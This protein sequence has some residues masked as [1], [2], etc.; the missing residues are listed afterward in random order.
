MTLE[1]RAELEFP[2]PEDVGLKYREYN[3][4]SANGLEK[5]VGIIG[6]IHLYNET[7]KK[8]VDQVML[9]YDAIAREGIQTTSLLSTMV[10][11]STKPILWIIKKAIPERKYL[12]S[13][14]NIPIEKQ[15][16]FYDLEPEET[17]TLGE[18]I[19]LLCGFLVTIAFLPLVYF[20]IKSNPHFRDPK[21][22]DNSYYSLV[23]RRDKTMAKRA[24]EII[25]QEDSGNVLL[26][27]GGAHLEGVVQHLHQYLIMEETK[28][29]PETG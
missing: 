5:K 25:Q 26:V 24:A 11:H 19:K 23:H 16:H 1:A 10:Y 4:S 8:F 13:T 9:K 21:N 27:V 17:L 18:N 22:R 6:E 2:S 20:R 15:M 12:F 29:F 3:I 14:R 7:E 28:R